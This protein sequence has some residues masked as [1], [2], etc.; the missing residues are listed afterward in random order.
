[1]P[2][3]TVFISST[4]KDLAL[5][6]Q[7]VWE[8]LTKF[9][10]AVRGMEQFGAQTTGPLETC[11]AEVAHCDVYVGIIAFRLGSIDAQS[12]QPFT[13]LEYEEAVRL[14]T[15]IL[16]YIADEDAALFPYS[17]IDTYAKR[18]S[19]LASFKKRLREDHTVDSFSTPED[20]AQKLHRDFERRFD[21]R[22]TALSV[23][24]GENT[25]FEKSAKT[26]R[27]FRLTP[28]RFNGREIRLS[29]AFTYGPFPA[30]R[31]L[32]R[33][34]NLEYGSTIGMHVRIVKPDDRP[35]AAGFSELYATGFRTDTLRA[36]AEEKRSEI[37]AALLFSENDV[38]RTSA[39]FFGHSYNPGE[40]EGPEDD[41]V[42]VPPEGKVIMLFTKQ[43]D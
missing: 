31:N 36:L 2:S 23:P 13:Q 6:R 39:E 9:D 26:L 33:Q 20:L 22:Q 43:A 34:F 11:L 38:G 35:A 14:K 1:M 19:Q 16:V 18:R 41:S 8:V 7:A 28:K 17:A 3:K 40:E 21:P 37:F 32:C 42:Y 29:V 10:V 12:R 15:E 27:E 5:H 25:D 4:F 30:S 24:S